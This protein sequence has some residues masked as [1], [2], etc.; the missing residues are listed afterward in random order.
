M[1]GQG[2]SGI[3]VDAYEVT[4]SHTQKGM[5][6]RSGPSAIAAAVLQRGKII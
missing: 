2:L 1:V 6:Q 3:G 5:E 4:P